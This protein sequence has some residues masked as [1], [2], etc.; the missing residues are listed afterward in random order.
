VGRD[1]VIRQLQQNR[2]AWDADVLEPIS[3][4]VAAADRVV[5]RFVWRV[6]GQ[7]HEPN[8]ELTTVLAQGADLLP[9][10]LVG[11]RRRPQSR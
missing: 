5:A 7:G 11:S 3:D 9:G 2:A 4:F 1:A 8:L 10:V 6:V